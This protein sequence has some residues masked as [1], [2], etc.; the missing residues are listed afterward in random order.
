MNSEWLPYTILRVASFLTPGDQRSKWLRE[1]RS[2]LWY[3]PQ[4]G[5]TRFCLGAFGDALWLRRE[6]CTTV[7]LRFHLESPLSCVAF[8]SA[9]AGLSIFV[10]LQLLAPRLQPST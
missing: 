5:A 9:L 8:L 1:W 10:M 3:I 2:E 7:K 6:N 4:S